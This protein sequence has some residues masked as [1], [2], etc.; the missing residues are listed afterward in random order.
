MWLLLGWF[1][2]V[3]LMGCIV[4]FATIIFKMLDDGDPFDDGG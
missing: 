1:G 2:M 3:L 4:G